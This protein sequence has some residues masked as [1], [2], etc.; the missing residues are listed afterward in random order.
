MPSLTATAPNQVWTW[1]ITKLATAQKGV[2]LMAYVIIDPY[3]R[4]VVGWT[5]AAKEFKH[6]AAQLFAET[7]ASHDI[8]PGLHVHADR[9]STMKSDTFAQLLDSLGASRSFSKPRVSNDNAFSSAIGRGDH[10]ADT[11]GWK[12]KVECDATWAS[13]LGRRPWP[14][15]SWTASR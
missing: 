6:L 3:S 2:F 5:I 9:G 1:D 7:I 11:G 14:A 10:Y 8:E 12:P 13:S 15:S 4:F